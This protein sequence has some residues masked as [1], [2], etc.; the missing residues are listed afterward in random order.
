LKSD[1]IS[2]SKILII[3]MTEEAKVS[4]PKE[5]KEEKPYAN[6]STYIF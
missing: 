2:I 6:N 3:I 4:D 1:I 5:K